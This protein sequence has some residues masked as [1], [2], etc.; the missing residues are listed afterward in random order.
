MYARGMS[1]RDIQAH[2]EDLY[3]VQ[4]SAALV[5]QVTNAV[6]EDVKTRQNRSLDEVYPIVYL[7]VI[8]VKSRYSGHIANAASC[9]EQ[10]QSHFSAL[11]GCY[12]PMRVIFRDPAYMSL[13]SATLAAATF[14]KYFAR[15]ASSTL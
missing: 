5:S 10:Q 4:V 13:F 7:G 6:T 12:P 15:V 1:T 8:R 9:P 2:H 11:T 3:S 14:I